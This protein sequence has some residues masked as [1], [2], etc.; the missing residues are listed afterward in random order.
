MKL[1]AE[2]LKNMPISV[3]VDQESLDAA[4]TQL[5]TFA[6]S[7]GRTIT[8]PINVAP[9]SSGGEDLPAFAGGG[10]IRGAGTG[11]SDSILAR[12]SNGEFVMKAAAVRKYGVSAL[13]NINNMSLPKFNT[14][15]MVGQVSDSPRQQNIG[16][17][18][19]NLPSGDT[20]S[21]DVAG[22]SNLDDLHRA[23]LKYGRTRK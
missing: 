6:E 9:A 12:L 13:N 14:G 3:I 23:A 10:Q 22:T 11:T 5:Q 1:E 17:V 4:K 8:I 20:F 15:G 2:T 18:Q 21:V 7:I 19:F 16:T